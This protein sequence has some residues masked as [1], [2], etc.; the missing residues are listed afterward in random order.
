MGGRFPGLIHAKILAIEPAELKGVE[1]HSVI[2]LAHGVQMIRAAPEHLRRATQ[3]EIG[4]SQYNT[5]NTR[6]LPS[7][8]RC[9]QPH[10]VD[11]GPPPTAEESGEIESEG[12]RGEE[13]PKP[14]DGAAEEKYE[15]GADGVWKL[16][17]VAG[18]LSSWQCAKSMVQTKVR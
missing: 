18:R 16:T 3:L 5:T 8:A 2:W 12:D 1:S 17:D 11:L 4:L 9:L 15:R 13:P 6:V 14:I 7:H 10:F